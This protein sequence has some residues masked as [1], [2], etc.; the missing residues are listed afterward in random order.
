MLFLTFYAFLIIYVHR[1]LHF[2]HFSRKHHIPTD[3]RTNGRTDGPT[4]TRSYRDSRTHLKSITSVWYIAT[5]GKTLITVT[6][7]EEGLGDLKTDCVDLK[8]LDRAWE[9]AER[10]SGGWT[11]F[12]RGQR[13]LRVRGQGSTQTAVWTNGNSHRYFLRHHPHYTIFIALQ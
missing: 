1:I 3:R 8:E 7:T 6:G 2:V 4:D 11:G 13:D 5:D 9:R 10:K 12:N